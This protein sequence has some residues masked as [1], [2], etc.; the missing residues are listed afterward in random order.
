MHSHLFICNKLIELIKTIAEMAE[1]D[2]N[3]FKLWYV[4]AGLNPLIKQLY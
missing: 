4:G 1:G 3:L 2:R